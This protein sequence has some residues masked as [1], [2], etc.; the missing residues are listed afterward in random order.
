MSTFYDGTKLLSMRDINGN[1]PEIYLC[2]SN[3]SAGKTTFFNRY[4]IKR[5]LNY[6]EKFV[7]IYRFKYELDS[8]AEKFFN[9]VKSLFFTDYNMTAKSKAGGMYYDLLLSKNGDSK[10]EICGYAIAL[11]CA[12]QIKKYSHLMNDAQ[13]MLFDEFQSETNHYASNE[14][15][16]LI[17]VHTS[18]ARGEG[19]QCRYLPIFMLSNNVS[20]LNP[21]F[22]ALGVSTR[23]RENT[24]FLR[25]NGFVLGQG[26]N[27]SASTALESSAFNRAFKNADYVKYASQ[28]SYLNDN[29]AFIDTPKGKS[30]YLCT[31]RYKNKDFGVFEFAE[32]GIIYCSDTADRTYPLKLAVTT[33]DLRIN[34]V[35][36]KKNDLFIANLRYY[37]D[38]GC[39]RFKNLLCKDC[40]LSTLSY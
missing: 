23:L 15:N 27:Q 14:L 12:D 35:M 6:G 36:I 25:G 13:R 33:E 5:F 26:Y 39:F 11:N 9:G 20:L 17:S 28:K 24:N 34:Y 21:Y 31:I 32:L 1:K 37:F 18:L 8:I 22:V 7:L 29:T 4:F 30:N 19:K 10:S 2:T 40:I 16:K 38:N 3:R